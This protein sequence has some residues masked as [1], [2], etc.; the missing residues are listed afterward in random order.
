MPLRVLPGIPSRPLHG[1]PPRRCPPAADDD[2]RA[3][4]P[5]VDPPAQRILAGLDLE[6]L[7]LEASAIVLM[8]PQVSPQAWSRRRSV[9]GARA[10]D[11]FLHAASPW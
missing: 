6:A 4:A 5:D 2:I 9:G 11:D 7:P 10:G 3:S 1:R 8:R